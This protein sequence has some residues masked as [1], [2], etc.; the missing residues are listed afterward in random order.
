M[1]CQGYICGSELRKFVVFLYTC[2]HKVSA[3]FESSVA[4]CLNSWSYGKLYSFQNCGTEIYEKAENGFCT[5]KVC[6]FKTSHRNKYS[7]ILYGEYK[8]LKNFSAIIK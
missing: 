6:D 3:Y 8:N 5:K 7:Q 2:R 1:G 4:D